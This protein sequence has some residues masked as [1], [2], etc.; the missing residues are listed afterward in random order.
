MSQPVLK[1]HSLKEVKKKREFPHIY[2]MLAIIIGVMT[3]ATYLVPAGAYDRVQ[4]EDGREMIAPT[5]YAELESSP[6]SLL[7]MLK[8]VPQGM[9]EAAPVIFFTFVI[10]GVFVTLRSAGVI[11]LGVGKIAKSFSHKPKLLI[12]VFMFTF[13]LIACFI[14]TPELAIVYVPVIM[15]LM[16]SLGYDRVT[17]AAIAL[18]GT[19]A[20]FTAA[21][22]NPFTV[23][24][25][26]MVAGLPLYSG[27][28]YRMVCFLLIISIGMAYVMR[29]AEKNR[30][31]PKEVIKPHAL[32]SSAT[33]RQKVAGIV[34]GLF[35]IGMIAGV[36]LYRWDM[37]TLGGYF[38]AMGI[39]PALIVGMNSKEIAESFNEGFRDVLVGAMVC[40]IARG[41]AVVMNEGQIMDTIVYGISTVISHLPESVTVIGMLITQSVFNFFVP[42][43]SGQALIMMP[44]MAPLADLVGITRQTAILAFQFGDG[45]SNIL[46]PTSGYFMATLAIAGV[47]WNRWV[48][49]ILPLFLLWMTAGAILLVVANLIGWS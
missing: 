36:I 34:T 1:E 5:S 25:A 39:I 2:F 23:G 10:G 49:F 20:G 16:L 35:F 18:C 9:V 17:A 37:V 26:Q 47:G 4:G 38:I 15:P 22:T 45:F 24:T 8:A 42:S 7:G 31:K 41:V 19:I 44:I 48:K 6:V 29:Y 12:P 11:E 43:G 13:A 32:K 21:L 28:I 40:G 33:N 3:I 30:T 14:G 27:M 46:F